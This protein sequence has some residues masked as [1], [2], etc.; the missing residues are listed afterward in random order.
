MAAPPSTGGLGVAATQS[1]MED[2]EVTDHPR[3][4]TIGFVLAAM[5]SRE[6]LRGGAHTLRGGSNLGGGQRWHAQKLW[7]ILMLRRQDVKL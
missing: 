4:L 3:G 5:S 6:D 1:Y 2:R 7:L